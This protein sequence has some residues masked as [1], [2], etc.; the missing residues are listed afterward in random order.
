[1]TSRSKL[2]RVGE[3]S[4]WLAVSKSTI[5]KWVELGTF[6]QP[7]VLGED[8]GRRSASR[9]EESAVQEWLDNRRR[10]VQE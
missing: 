2:L 3:L 6:P 9:W 8:D 7:I 10:G 5:Y 4:E 1:M